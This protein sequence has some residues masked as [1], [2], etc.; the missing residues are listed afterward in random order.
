[1]SDQRWREL[2]RSYGPLIYARCRKMLGDDVAA[3]DAAQE[4][5][6][7][8]YKHLDKVK[9]TREAL[10][11]IYRIATHYCLNVQ[12]AGKQRAVPVAETPERPGEHAEDSLSHRDFLLKLLD[13]LPEKVHT[14]AWLHH[15]EGL[16]VGEVALMLDISR[17]TVMYRLAMLV[18]IAS[19]M[20]AEKA[21]P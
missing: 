12:R 21:E 16:E 13:R 4:T 19:S 6:I 17:R 15:V 5:F 20:R 1:M 18:Q 9:S 14:V 8:A 7:R 11:W 3:E 2:Y 10:P